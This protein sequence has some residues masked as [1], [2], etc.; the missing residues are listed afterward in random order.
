M[1][2]S[3]GQGSGTRTVTEARR[4]WVAGSGEHGGCPVWRGDET[5]DAEGS[6]AGG[7]APPSARPPTPRA[8][9]S[10]LCRS[11]PAH[12][13]GVSQGI[14]AT[15]LPGFR[16]LAVS[17]A[18]RNLEIGASQHESP[19]PPCGTSPGHEGLRARGRRRAQPTR[20]AQRRMVSSRVWLPRVQACGTGRSWVLSQWWLSI[21]R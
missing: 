12:V 21:L 20:G 8:C 5:R 15:R 9:V 7:R 14:V 17:K 13:T 6:R 4:S 10:S 18:S 19:L 16:G 3:L 1:K 2:V 11:P